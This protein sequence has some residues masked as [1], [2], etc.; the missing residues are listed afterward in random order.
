MARHFTRFAGET[1]NAPPAGWTPF[2]NSLDVWNVEDDG[3]GGRRLRA[4][5]VSPITSSSS[6]ASG[7]YWDAPGLDIGGTVEVVSKLRAYGTNAYVGLALR[8]VIASTVNQY[9]GAAT[10]NAFTRLDLRH[11]T[12]EGTQQATTAFAL[13]NGVWHGMRTRIEGT[14]WTC[15]VWVWNDAAADY[16][17]STATSVSRSLSTARTGGGTFHASGRVGLWLSAS[18]GNLS[19]VDYAMVGVA[20]GGVA[21]LSEMVAPGAPALDPI[22]ARVPPGVLNVSWSSATDPDAVSGDVLTYAGEYSVGGGAWTPLFGPQAGLSYAWDMAAFSG[23]TLSVRVR[24]TDPDGLAG[25]WDDATFRVSPWDV[26]EPAPGSAWGSCGPPPA[27]TWQ[28]C[29]TPPVSAWAVRS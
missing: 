26:C 13:A 4:K 17:E 14:T 5:A 7:L 2:A 24:A 12:N 29:E 19:I 20:T 8:G 25:T 3:A 10:K 28:G 1:I 23:R 9:L 11:G 27:S 18:N 15:K 21:P 16:G 22:P 6:Y